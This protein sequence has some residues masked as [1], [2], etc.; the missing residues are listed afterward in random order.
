MY[1]WPQLFRGTS[2]F[3]I[4]SS[5]PKCESLEANQPDIK[6]E[7]MS[8][9]NSY[10]MFSSTFRHLSSVQCL[11]V[12]V[13]FDSKQNACKLICF[14]ILIHFT[15]GRVIVQICLCLYKHFAGL[16]H[17]S[18]AADTVVEEFSSLAIQEERRPGR[19]DRVVLKW[20][21][22]SLQPFN[23][24]LNHFAIFNHIE[25]I[26]C[27]ISPSV[28]MCVWA[29]GHLIVEP[30]NQGWIIARQHSFFPSLIVLCEL[31]MNLLSLF[32]SFILLVK[33]LG[34]CEHC[35]TVGPN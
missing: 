26:I 32:L 15:A 29:G 9:W 31:N 11:P 4:A 19:T 3:R 27:I 21:C 24:A 22:H 14:H 33:T 5:Q 25:H 34:S 18:G 2:N 12:V 17:L 8:V 10:F 23:K 6:H 7:I 28:C 30:Q 1:L 13:R 20:R 16:A 35:L